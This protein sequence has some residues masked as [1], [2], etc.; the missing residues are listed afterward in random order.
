MGLSINSDVSNGILRSMQA[1]SQRLAKTQ[2]K[3]ATGKRI[4]SASDDAAGLAISQR[5][6]AEVAG[7]QQGE[8]NVADGQSLV[9][10]AEGSLQSTHETLD[11]MRE[12]AVQARNGTLSDQ[13]RATLQQ[14][15][16]HLSAQIDQTAVGTRFGERRLLDGSASGAEAVTITD[17]RGGDSAIDIADTRAQALGVAGQDVAADGTIDAI[18]AAIDRVSSVRSELGAYDTR[19]SHQTT[20]LASARAN[21]EDARSRIEDADYAREVAEQTRDRILQDLQLAGHRVAGQ[22]Q[23][24]VLDLL[25]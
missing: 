5:L 9:R 21:A 22:S 15:Y 20:E 17:G 4:A 25:G 10:T 8:R 6:R 12:L 24:R 7:L 13:D 19:F 23:R 3:L 14:E 11:R 18:D 1:S 16:D 2:A